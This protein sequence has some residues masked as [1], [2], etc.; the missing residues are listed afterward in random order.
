M[1]LLMLTH[2]SLAR[3]TDMVKAG[4]T[5]GQ[6][7]VLGFAGVNHFKR[8]I[9]NVRCICGTEQIVSTNK[10]RYTKSCGCIRSLVQRR[11]GSRFDYEMFNTLQDFDEMDIE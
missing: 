1:S 2:Q 3:L 10:L 4:D 8:K 7:T 5:F 6:R 9:W 11:P